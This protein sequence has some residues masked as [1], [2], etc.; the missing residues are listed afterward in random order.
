MDLDNKIKILKPFKNTARAGYLEVYLR[1]P[2]SKKTFKVHRLVA[3]F[4][5]ENINDK[6]EVNH[7][8][9]NKKNKSGLS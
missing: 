3:Q 1:L 6:K 7:I 2:G 9:G 5:L 8:D 4:W